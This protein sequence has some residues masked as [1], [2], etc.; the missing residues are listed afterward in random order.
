MPH[1]TDPRVLLVER[2][3]LSRPGFFRIVGI[4]YSAALESDEDLTKIDHLLIEVV[5]GRYGRITAAVNT[6]S[7][8]SR[9]AGFEA[10][11][12]VG[13]ISSSWVEMPGVVIEEAPGLDYAAIEHGVSFD[14]YEPHALADMLI[15]K[16]REAHRMEIWGEIYARNELGIHQIHSRRASRAMPRDLEGHDGAIKFYY[17]DANRAELF[18]FKFDGQP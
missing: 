1:R 11:V 8:Y 12:R 13:I 15:A 9:N 6:L 3:R 14:F 16:T 7:R 17:P 18:L 4:P 5:V 2:V 10:R